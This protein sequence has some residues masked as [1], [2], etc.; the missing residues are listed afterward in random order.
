[1]KKYNLY[2]KADDKVIIRENI[3]K[4]EIDKILN[5]LTEH[6]QS[7]LRIT[8]VKEKEDEQER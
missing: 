5:T 1:M 4:E 6:P 8:R 2:Y 7:E 3:S